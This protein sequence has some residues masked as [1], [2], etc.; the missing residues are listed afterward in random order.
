M[1]RKASTVTEE[2][3]NIGESTQEIVD[4]MPE[5][6]V[7][8]NN[9]ES[10]TEVSGEVEAVEDADEDVEAEAAEDPDADVD[11]GTDVDEDYDVKIIEEA[12]EDPP[13]TPRH[14][15]SESAPRV[16]QRNMARIEER[17]RQQ[18]QAQDTIDL[19][20]FRRKKEERQLLVVLE[21]CLDG[22]LNQS[23]RRTTLG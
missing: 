2:T 16:R 9:P 20:A 4:S 13:I 17:E 12:S 8:D 15:A 23:R 3:E 7:P 10:E 22:M 21:L 1:P 11:D 19:P 14:T 5:E 6:S 18:A